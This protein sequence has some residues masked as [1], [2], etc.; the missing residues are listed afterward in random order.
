MLRFFS[1]KSLIIISCFLL[2]ISVA[3][4]QNSEAEQV[5]GHQIEILKD[6]L[7]LSEDQVSKLKE[8]NKEYALKTKN[9]TTTEANKLRK[10]KE[11][12]YKKVLNSD[13]YAKWQK[14]KDEINAEAQMKYLTSEEYIKNHTKVIKDNVEEE[15]NEVRESTD[16]INDR[17][18]SEIEEGAHK[19]K[20][21]VSKVIEDIK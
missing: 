9:L 6:K 11:A 18:K 5:I 19:T 12:E 4:A 7:D 2:S 13:Q 8:L 21:A 14:E 10:E 3:K 20:E 15:Y 17:I 1:T 16:K